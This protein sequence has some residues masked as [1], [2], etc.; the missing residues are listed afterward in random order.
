MSID[1][2]DDC[3]FWYTNQYLKYRGEFN[4]SHLD[5]IFQ[6]SGVRRCSCI[7]T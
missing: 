2:T 3:T 4:W 1:P 6:I 5:H 7:R